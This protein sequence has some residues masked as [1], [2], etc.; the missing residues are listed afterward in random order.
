MAIRFSASLGSL[1]SRRRCSASVSAAPAVL[2]A[3]SPYRRRADDSDVA[4][5]PHP[6][7]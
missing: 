1:F 4:L 2:P 5:I 3:D 6:I 7:L